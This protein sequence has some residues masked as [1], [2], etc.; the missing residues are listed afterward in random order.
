MSIF[1]PSL[2]LYWI[3]IKHNWIL[4]DC[5]IGPIERERVRE[6][7]TERDRARERVRERERERARARKEERERERVHEQKDDAT[8]GHLPLIP[9]SQYT[10]NAL[11][12]A[13]ASDAM[14]QSAMIPNDA[15]ASSSLVAFQ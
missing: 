6:I 10:K 4:K 5:Y 9:T 7:E 13:I 14:P 3:P 1:H 8:F 2:Y 15:W 11:A 12:N